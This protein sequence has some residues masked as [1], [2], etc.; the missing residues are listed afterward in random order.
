MNLS[1]VDLTKP[2]A[3]G[4]SNYQMLVKVEIPTEALKQEDDAIQIGET[5]EDG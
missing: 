4:D 2:E 1:K 5:R 3:T